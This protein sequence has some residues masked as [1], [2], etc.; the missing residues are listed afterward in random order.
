[1]ILF[2]LIPVNMLYG[3]LPSPDLLHRFHFS[4]V[5]LSHCDSPLVREAVTSHPHRRP[6]ALR[7]DSGGLLL[8]SHNALC[9]RTPHRLKPP[10]AHRRVAEDPRA[11]VILEAR[12]RRVRQRADSVPRDS[13]G[14]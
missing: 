4:M 13:Q 3:R 14:L 1:M 6:E 10:L 12:D 8:S 9:L 2:F 5:R 11:A 7:H